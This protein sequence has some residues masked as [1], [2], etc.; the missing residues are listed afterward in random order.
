MN[1]H[2]LR[3]VLIYTVWSW[4][5]GAG[6]DVRRVKS[7]PAHSAVNGAT[8]TILGV[9]NGWYRIEYSPGHEGYVSGDYVTVNS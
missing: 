7:Q 5:T 1:R 6:A 3:R 2:I 8:V 4:S 9:E